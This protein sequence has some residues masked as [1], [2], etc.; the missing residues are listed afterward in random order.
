[1]RNCIKFLSENWTYNSTD[2]CLQISKVEFFQLK[3]INHQSSAEE[4]NKYISEYF[5]KAPHALSL[6]DISNYT[7]IKFNLNKHKNFIRGGD[8]M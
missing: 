4:W 3:L 7:T 5:R 8:T 6:K 2:I 1:M